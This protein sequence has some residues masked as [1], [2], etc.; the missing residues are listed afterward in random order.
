MF[1]F[2]VCYEFSRIQLSLYVYPVMV[3]VTITNNLRY[4]DGTTEDNTII[5]I[6]QCM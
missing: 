4:Q 1:L 3:K 5:H 6:L 2:R